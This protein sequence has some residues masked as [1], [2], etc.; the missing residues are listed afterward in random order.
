[1]EKV[2]SSGRTHGNN[3]PLLMIWKASTQSSLS[4]NK[5]ASKMLRIFGSQLRKGNPRGIG[6]PT[7]QIYRSQRRSTF[8]C[9]RNACNTGKFKV[10]ND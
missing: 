1:M 5:I 6:K 7:E 2:L 3:Y 10:K 4:Y 9:G 8:Y